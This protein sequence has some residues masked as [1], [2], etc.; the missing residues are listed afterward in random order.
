MNRRTPR[1]PRTYTLLPYT[2]LVG[3]EK[4]SGVTRSVATGK[5]LTTRE[6]NNLLHV[7]RAVCNQ[8]HNE[9]DNGSGTTQVVAALELAGF[10]GPKEKTVRDLL[11]AVREVT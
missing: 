6:G 1:A 10:D 3:S 2:A 8:A 5:A 4:G 7:S 11:K 9:L